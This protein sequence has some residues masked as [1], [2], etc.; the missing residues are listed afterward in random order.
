[1]KRAIFGLKSIAL[2]LTAILLILGC[3]ALTQWQ[4]DRKSSRDIANS[5]IERNIDQVPA[6]IGELL[7]VDNAPD[8][9][10][11]WRHAEVSGTLGEYL[12]MRT[13]YSFGKYGYGVIA[14]IT[15]SSGDRY[16]IDLGWIPAGL[17]ATDL[18]QISLPTASISVL[19]RIRGGDTLDRPGPRGSL[20][21]MSREDFS[22]VAKTINKKR[23]ASDGGGYL[24][25]ETITPTSTSMP[26]PMPAPEISSGPHAA[27][28]VQWFVFAILI[29]LGRFLLLREDVRNSKTA[30]RKARDKGQDLS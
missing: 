30:A 27:Y 24:E 5:L 26:I 10:V 7:K 8:P 22:A 2:T 25:A 6:P 13:R 14:P 1:M 17:S 16:W 11:R 19:G 21:G 20:F 3:F 4:W 23:M 28:A 9:E 29:G 18:P 15:T 12:L